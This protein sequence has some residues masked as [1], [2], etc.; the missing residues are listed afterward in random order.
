MAR[1]TLMKF[2]VSVEMIQFDNLRSDIKPLTPCSLIW[3]LPHERLGPWFIYGLGILSQKP[4]IPEAESH[5]PNTL[6]C[7]L[8]FL[9]PYQMGHINMNRTRF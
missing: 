8:T 5:W 1:I 3:P 7:K 2:K 9:K 6:L 4:W